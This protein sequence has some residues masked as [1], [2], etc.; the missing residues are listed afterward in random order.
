MS[1]NLKIFTIVGAVVVV[2]LAIVLV[3]TD[4][5]PPGEDVSGTIGK[6]KK[7]RSTR[8]TDEDVRLDES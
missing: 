7:Y 6:A 4:T 3:A 5:F 8:I 2:I 1:K